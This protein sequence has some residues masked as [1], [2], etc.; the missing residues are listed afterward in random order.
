MMMMEKREGDELDD[1][2]ICPIAIY[3]I[4]NSLAVMLNTLGRG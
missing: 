1:R 4:L 2:V 3:P